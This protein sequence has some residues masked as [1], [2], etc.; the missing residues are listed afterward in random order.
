MLSLDNLPKYEN[1]KSTKILKPWFNVFSD[2]LIMLLLAVPIFVGGMELASGRYVCLP[3]VDCS[4]TNNASLC[5]NLTNTNGKAKVVVTQL[6]HTRDYDYV[7][8]ECKKTA[9]PWFHSYFSLLLFSQAFILLL[10]NNLWLKYPWTASFVDNFYAL[11]EECYNFPGA[12]FARLAPNNNQEPITTSATES[13]SFGGSSSSGS[14]R[15]ISKHIPSS[16]QDED[17]VGVDLVT[18][19]AVNTLHEK[20]RRFNDYVETSQQIQCV[21]LFQAA[22]QAL[23]TSTFFFVNNSRFKDMKGTAKCSVDESFPVMYGYFTCSHNLSTLFERALE[24]FLCILGAIHIVCLGII[25]WTIKKARKKG[26]HFQNELKRWRLPSDLKPA[27]GGMGFLLHLLHA[28]D[29]LYTVQFVIYMSEKHNRKFK[30]A[31]LDNEWPVEKL[32]KCFYNDRKALCLKGLSGIPS[33][34]F[35]FRDSVAARLEVLELNACG[36]L[37]ANHFDEFGKF[38]NLSMLSLINCGLTKVPDKLFELETL[39]IVSLRHNS[40]KEIQ[41]GIRN[42]TE[43]EEFDISY[44]K[45]EAIHRSIG[46]LKSL[47]CVNISNNPKFIIGLPGAINSVLA[48]R[49]LKTLVVSNGNKILRSLPTEDKGRFEKVMKDEEDIKGG[50]T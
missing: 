49:S 38:C 1:N 41:F 31:I 33:S 21:Y 24:V 12:H 37:Q 22:F 10:T 28:Y 8:S 34:L 4:V 46:T 18:A 43:L 35:Q 45:L 27:Q 36:P 30:K 5:Q 23:L 15:N 48:C 14:V 47:R 9:F 3:A 2:Y 26:Y 11:A 44:N 42:L 50:L 7:N 17:I 16:C 29:K 25:F 20:I 13:C 40:I 32:E 39:K 19:V 6:K